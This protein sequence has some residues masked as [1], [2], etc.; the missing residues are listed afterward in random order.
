ML[1]KDIVG[2]D[3]V[4]QHLV[5]MVQQ[6]R[7]SHAM[8]FLGKQGSGNLPLA[9]ALAQYL[10]CE[11]VSRSINSQPV[12]SLFGEVEVTEVPAVSEACDSC[13]ACFKAKQ[14]THPDIHFSY[15][16]IPRKSGDKP[17][18]VDYIKE[19]RSFFLQHPYGNV[20]DWLQFIGAENRQG[21]IT[22]EECADIIRKLSLKSFES[23]Y[24][25]LIMWM[26]EYLGKEGNKLLKLIEEPPD[27]TLFILVAENEEQILPTILSRTLLVKVP[28]LEDNEVEQAL[29]ERKGV[30]PDEAKQVAAIAQGNYHEAL[31]VLQSSGEDW[32][33]I[34][35]NWVTCITRNDLAAQVKWVEFMSA[36]LGREKQKQFLRYYNHILEQCVRVRIIGAQSVTL[37]EAEAD[38]VNRFNKITGVTQQQA[39]INEIDNAMYFIERNANGKM[40]F[41]AL[42]IKTYH[43][44]KN[45]VVA[46]TLY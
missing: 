27:N 25:I 36:E 12:T 5:E 45:R 35:L 16:A 31:Q 2:Q 26:P 32:L 3:A 23:D 33:K 44:I 40:L 38:F 19:W 37:S 30:M 8:L 18:S 6:N 20:Y 15:P 7:I 1:F 22:A 13:P 46:S 39:I 14:L 29:V 34:L 41:H 28:L 24:K 11:K 43:I 42:T 9:V 17:K 10:V 21:N 4:K